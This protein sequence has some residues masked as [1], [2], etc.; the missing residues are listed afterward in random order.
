MQQI[1]NSV[2][3]FDEVQAIPVHCM[4][5]F[6]LA[7]NFLTTFCNTTVVLC[8]ATQPSTALLK[9]NNVMPC[10]EMAGNPNQYAEV[11]RRVKIEDKTHIPGGMSIEDLCTLTLERFHKMNSVLVIV[12][13]KKTAKNCM[14]N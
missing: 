14:N 6:N 13:T 9:E 11:F 12:N 3:I 2:I 10:V 7:V 8:T 5:L 1:C 4:E